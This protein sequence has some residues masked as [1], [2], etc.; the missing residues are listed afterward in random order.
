MKSTFNHK[1]LLENS[2][3]LATKEEPTSVEQRPG[4]YLGMPGVA[5][6]NM[7]YE[8]GDKASWDTILHI[9]PSSQSGIEVDA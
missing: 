6:P 3:I 7:P 5:P 8:N 9:A 2:S 4:D 1:A